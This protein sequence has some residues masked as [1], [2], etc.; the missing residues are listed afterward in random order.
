MAGTVLAGLLGGAALAQEGA[1][2]FTQGPATAPAP[3]NAP[4]ALPRETPTPPPMDPAAAPPR[5]ATAAPPRD[6][7][8][9]PPRDAND[10]GYVLEQYPDKLPQTT[11]ECI[12]FRTLYDWKA[13][14]NSNLIVW[15][16]SKNHPYHI[17]LDRPCQGLR[18]A[19]SI[20]FT[21]RDS[22]LC[23]FGG[24]AVLV[25][26]G[27][28]RADRCPIGGIT[29]LTEESLKSLLAQAPGKGLSEKKA[30]GDAKP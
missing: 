1:M 22:R 5:D 3:R 9:A 20:G 4:S 26:S 15:A 29:K 16:P 14:N 24:D 28:G 30:E 2:G 17:Q 13:L 6:A 11:N 19:Y 18:F 10:P 7:A 21:S 12:F 27:G 8:A 25:E 23:G